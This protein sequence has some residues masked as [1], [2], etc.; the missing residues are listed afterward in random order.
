M[1]SREEILKPL[2]SDLKLGSGKVSV[3]IFDSYSCVHCAK[4]YEEIFPTLQKDFI[5][6]NKITFIHKE[7][8]LDTRAMFGIKTVHCSKNKLESILELYKNQK[9]LLEDK[10]YQ[11]ILKQK[12]NITDDCIANFNESPLMKKSFEYSKV[13]DIR[14]TPTVFIN[15]V[16]L[17]K[18]NKV[19]L[20][21][22][23]HKLTQ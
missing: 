7:F 13:L 18:F 1:P 5:N 16:K 14:G 15:G 21:N 10:D 19:I 3:V 4:F 2:S 20:L 23:L 6:P 17:E 12:F 22:E 9:I 8:P 11:K